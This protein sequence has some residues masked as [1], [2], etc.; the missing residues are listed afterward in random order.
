MYVSIHEI[1]IFAITE[2]V[3]HGMTKIMFI[4]TTFYTIKR[5]LENP[6]MK[7]LLV[8]LLWRKSLNPASGPVVLAL[9][10][11]LRSYWRRPDTDPGSTTSRSPGGVRRQQ[12]HN[13]PREEN[14]VGIGID[15]IQSII[16]VQL[17]TCNKIDKRSVKRIKR[18]FHWWNSLEYKLYV[19]KSFGLFFNN[20]LPNTG[21][22]TW[23][24]AQ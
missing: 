15:K 16:N 13:K 18:I 20:S 12:E 19:D 21:I 11:V 6:P 3:F 7:V 5:R 8:T 4:V 22:N 23:S 14:V 9:C 1:L 2:T 10:L 24:M 17:L